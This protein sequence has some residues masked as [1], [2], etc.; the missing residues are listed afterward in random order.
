MS[1]FQVVS[2]YLK[3]N[4]WNWLKNSKFENFY[5]LAKK[6]NQI[7]CLQKEFQIKFNWLIDHKKINSILS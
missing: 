7:D 4:Y 1:I 6:K 2:A 3:K 5:S